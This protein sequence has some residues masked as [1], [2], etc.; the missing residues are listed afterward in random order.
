M[1]SPSITYTFTNGTV[2]DGSQVNTNFNN[3]I[4]ALTDSTKDLDV[5]DISA[6]TGTI[7]TGTITT[8]GGTTFTFGGA[9]VNHTLT[10]RSLTLTHNNTTSAYFQILQNSTGNSLLDLAVQSTGDPYIYFNGAGISSPWS[11]GVDNSDSESFV[12]SASSTLGSSNMLRITTAGAATLTGR[13]TAAGVTVSDNILANSG[14]TLDIGSSGTRFAS[15][16]VGTVNGSG[17]STFAGTVSTSA[18]W[19]VAS[20]VG[21]DPGAA[22][23]EIRIGCVDLSAGNATLSLRTERAVAVDVIGASTHTLSVQIN[24]TTYKIL[25]ST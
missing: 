8:L 20:N 13:L 1:A 19:F 11:V 4:S 14:G 7:T 22:T 16:F 5:A 15:L 24:G 12:F 23:D 2:I 25:L 10:G 17:N 6:T 9:N 21:G 3:I 18:A